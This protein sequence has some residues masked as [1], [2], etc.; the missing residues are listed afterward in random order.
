[1]YKNRKANPGRN[2]IFSGYFITKSHNTSPLRVWLRQNIPKGPRCG[3]WDKE[4]K[5]VKEFE[6]T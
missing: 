3:T 4:D 1:M 6:Q 5:D 2:N